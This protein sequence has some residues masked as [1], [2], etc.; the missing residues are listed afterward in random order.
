ML[1]PNAKAFAFRVLPETEEAKRSVKASNHV[2]GI[3]KLRPVLAQKNSQSCG[4]FVTINEG[5]QRADEITRVRAVFA[6]TDGAPLEP[7]KATLQPH[8]IVETSPSRWHVY[9]LVAD[10]FPLDQFSI[11]QTAIAKKFGTDLSVKDLPRIMRVPG[12]YHNKQEPY[13]C[14][15]VE[16]SRRLQRYSLEELVNG[17]GLN[18]NATARSET[19]SRLIAEQGPQA[20]FAEVKR[21]LSYLNP[22]VPRDEWVRHIWALAHEFGEAGRE[23]AHQWSRGDLW[24]GEHDAN[25]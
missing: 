22:F 8:I 9:W 18:L 1:D 15:L 6:D 5:G 23:L 24:I 4:V 25:A 13:L 19:A 14:R 7:I 2:G 12:F 20:S 16:L 10:G 21:A 11:V 3:A 17:L